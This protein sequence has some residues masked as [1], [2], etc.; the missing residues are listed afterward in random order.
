MFSVLLIVY[1][2]PLYNVG[3]FWIHLVEYVKRDDRGQITLIYSNEINN[4]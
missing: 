4:V 2:V 3:I 1:A